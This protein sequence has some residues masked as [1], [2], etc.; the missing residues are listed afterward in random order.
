ME[1]TILKQGDYMSIYNTLRDGL[2]Y[3]SDIQTLTQI[4]FHELNPFPMRT[5]NH[6]REHHYKL[7]EAQKKELDHIR[8]NY[9]KN[10][11]ARVSSAAA[12]KPVMSLAGI[13]TDDFVDETMEDEIISKEIL[14][15]K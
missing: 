6:K 14:Q 2:E 7:L 8:Q 4:A 13:P 10:S 5:I 3:L 9:R 1:N 15:E 12:M 11:L